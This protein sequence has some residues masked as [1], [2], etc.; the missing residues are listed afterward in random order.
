MAIEDCLRVKDNQVLVTAPTKEQAAGIMVPLVRRIIASAP[1]G[2]VK[3]SKSDYRFNMHNGSTLILCGFD[4]AIETVRGLFAGNIYLEESA[5]TDPDEY[6]YILRSVL[7]PTLLHSRGRMTHFTTPSPT[8]EH[9]LHA[10]TVPKTKMSNSF[11]LRTIFDNPLLTETDVNEAMVEVGGEN[12]TAWKREFLCEI[13]KDP[14]KI[15]VGEFSESVHVV[16]GFKMPDHCHWVVGADLGFARDLS[17]LL[18]AFYDFE[19]AKF[20]VVDS[21]VWERATHTRKIVTDAKA[22]EAKYNLRNPGRFIDC[23]ARATA[24]LASEHNYP[25]GQLVKDNLNAQINA[26]K[27]AFSRNEIEIH[28]RCTH[29]IQTLNSQCWNKNKTDFQRT[30]TLGHADSLMALVYAFRMI[31][32]SNPFPLNWGRSHDRFYPDHQK[33]IPFFPG[34]NL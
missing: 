15:I 26:L 12:S 31:D 18:V 3:H 6:P 30:E 32:K 34:E 1:S 28:E 2:F 33:P 27:V 13:I 11:F 21:T 17:A 5:S 16:K 25:V 24:D 7:F 22:L 23:D 20:C 9:P 4:T 29:L 10:D 14:E 8:I 19:R